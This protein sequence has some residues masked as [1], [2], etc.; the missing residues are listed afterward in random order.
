MDTYLN[1]ENLNGENKMEKFLIEL[2]DSS[3]HWTE[4]IEAE[5]W[6]EAKKIAIKIKEDHNRIFTTNLPLH[7][8]I[9]IR[10]LGKNEEN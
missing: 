10:Q 8:V 6:I 5:N 3:G 2:E 9:V 4:T 7:R 1:G